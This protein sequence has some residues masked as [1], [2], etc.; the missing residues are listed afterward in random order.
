MSRGLWAFKMLYAGIG[1]LEPTYVGFVTRFDTYGMALFTL[2]LCLLAAIGI[3]I[4]AQ[5]STTSG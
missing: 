5:E 2:K 4:C 3:V 1:G